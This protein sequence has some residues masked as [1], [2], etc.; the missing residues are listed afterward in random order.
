LQPWPGDGPTLA[1][2]N[3]LSLN[4]FLAM[5]LMSIDLMA[6]AGFALPILIIAL[7]QVALM[8]L[9][10]APVCFWLL[11][12]NYDA[13]VTRAGLVGMGLGATPTA[14]A[15]MSALTARHGP[16]PRAFLIIPLVG[17][18]LIDAVNALVVNSALAIL[19]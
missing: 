7:A 16:S 1:L 12:R 8:L 6:L 3:H 4:L 14:I 11:G 10:M 17:A 13:A 9:V 15:N 5:S 18:M 19:G 2:V